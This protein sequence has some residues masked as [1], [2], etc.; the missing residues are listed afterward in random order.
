MLPICFTR[1]VKFPLEAFPRG[2]TC[3]TIRG[4][5]PSELSR[6]QDHPFGSERNGV[7]TLCSPT[8]CP[9]KVRQRLL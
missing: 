8:I 2:L 4:E 1:R 7:S 9:C 3:L 6:L 5:L